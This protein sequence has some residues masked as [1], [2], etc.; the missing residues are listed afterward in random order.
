MGN[1][2]GALGFVGGFA[3]GLN[4]AFNRTMDRRYEQSVR[5]QAMIQKTLSEID[6]PDMLDTCLFCTSLYCF[7]KIYTTLKILI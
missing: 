2:Y 1:G 5:N 3:S 4:D 7:L 6:I